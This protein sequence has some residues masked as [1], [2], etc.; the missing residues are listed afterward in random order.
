MIDCKTCGGTGQVRQQTRT[1]FGSFT[2]VGICATCAGKRKLPEKI[3]DKCNGETRIPG[4]RKLELHLPKD[5]A[6]GYTIA[7][8]KGGNAGREGKPDLERT[9]LRNG[10]L[11]GAYLILA[12][13][14]LGLDCAP[15]S[16][17]NEEKVNR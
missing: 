13:R 16:G 1:P 4:K 14:A 5:L 7:I 15:M 11:Q 8:P 6:D 2:R 3:C 9:G 10:S 12:A 17:F